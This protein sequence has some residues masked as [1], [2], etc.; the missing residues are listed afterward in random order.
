MDVKLPAA[1]FCNNW[2]E[3]YPKYEGVYSRDWLRPVPE[4][5]KHCHKK[6][7]IENRDIINGGPD[8]N[9]VFLFQKNPEDEE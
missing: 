4:T 7:C 3:I 2:S 1:M 5:F 8:W 9:G 6:P